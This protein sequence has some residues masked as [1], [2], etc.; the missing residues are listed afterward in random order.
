MWSYLHS[1][2][3]SVNFWHACVGRCERASVSDDAE[4]PPYIQQTVL[5]VLLL[6]LRRFPY[7][8]RASFQVSVCTVCQILPS[9]QKF[10]P[11]SV[12]SRDSPTVPIQVVSLEFWLQ[13]LRKIWIKRHKEVFD[14]TW[15]GHFQFKI[16]FE[17]EKDRHFCQRKSLPGL[18]IL[19]PVYSNLPSF[20]IAFINLSSKEALT[21]E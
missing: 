5:H 2:E 7:L 8:R 14:R 9:G 3:T 10:W 11:L 19:L 13:L 18:L 12:Y 16:Q 15:S 17:K 1:S 20:Y 6:H 21:E 4:E